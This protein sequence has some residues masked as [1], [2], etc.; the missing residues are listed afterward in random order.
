MATNNQTIDEEKMGSHL[1]EDISEANESVHENGLNGVL[2]KDFNPEPTSDPND[3][4][5]WPMGLKVY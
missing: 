4:L 5:N 2:T 3:P 1:K